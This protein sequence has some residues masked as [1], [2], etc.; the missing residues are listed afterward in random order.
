MSELIRVLE[1]IQPLKYPVPHI[2]TL[3]IQS[4]HHLCTQHLEGLSS[5]I[6]RKRLEPLY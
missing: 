2:L 6:I 4:Q 1:V 5:V 3:R